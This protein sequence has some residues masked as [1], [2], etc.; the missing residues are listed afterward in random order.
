MIFFPFAFLFLKIDWN[1]FHF[2]VLAMTTILKKVCVLTLLFMCSFTFACDQGYAWRNSYYVIQPASCG[3][4]HTIKSGEKLKLT[5]FLRDAALVP[6]QVTESDDIY[7]AM[8]AIVDNGE[9]EDKVMSKS[10]EDGNVVFETKTAC[11]GLGAHNAIFLISGTPGTSEED[12]IMTAFAFN[13]EMSEIPDF[14]KMEVHAPDYVIGKQPFTFEVDFKDTCGY[15]NSDIVA[16]DSI[17]V[18]LNSVETDEIVKNVSES[19]APLDDMLHEYEIDEAGV[20]G[21]FYISV[22]DSAENDAHA[23]SDAIT[24][25]RMC[26]L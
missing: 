12:V 17:Y 14:S 13:V 22:S 1:I 6:Q 11:V 7:K 8:Y 21:S 4:S 9:T 10:I 2:V 15:D 5:V 26:G 20:S 18:T 24:K 19:L 16:S 23:T 3:G 25:L